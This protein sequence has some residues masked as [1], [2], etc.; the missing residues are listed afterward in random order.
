MTE[1]APATAWDHETDLLVVGSGGGA[2]AAA[3]RGHDLGLRT[4][5]IEKSEHWG[6][7]TAISGGGLWIVG[8]PDA[9]AAGDSTEKGYAYL[10]SVVGDRVPDVRLRAYLETAPRMLDWLHGATRA[11]Y[12]ANPSFPDYYP[13]APGAMRIRTL[14]PDPIDARTL[15]AEYFRMRPG[16]RSL[17]LFGMTVG[18]AEARL[19]M[20]RLP[21][22]RWL[23]ARNVL[24]FWLDFPWRFRSRRDRILQSGAALSASLRRSMMDRNLVLWLETPMRRLFVEGGRVTGVEAEQKGRKIRIRVHRAVILG[25][26]GYEKSAEMRARHLPQPSHIDWTATTAP[27]TG[28]AQRA[29]EA[30]GAALD[31]MDCA[32]WSPTVR[33]PG[34]PQPP[35]FVERAQPGLIAVNRQGRRFVNE[36]YSYFR[37]GRALYA[38]EGANLPAWFIFD[39]AFR[40]KYRIGPLWP[41]VALPDWLLPRRW[42]GTCYF[43]AS[44]LNELAC[45]IGVDPAGLAETV[46]RINR[47]AETGIDEDFAKG[48]NSFDLAFGDPAHTPN[49]CLGPVR[50]PP[51]YAM[52][53]FPGDIGTKG[54]LVCDEHARVLRPDGSVIE[55][56]Y[57]I[58]NSSAAVTGNSY[59]GAGSPITSAMTFG[60]IAA[61]HVAA[62]LAAE[63]AGADMKRAAPER[64]ARPVAGA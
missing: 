25:A 6:G 41:S 14:Q 62:A 34:H 15:G 59:P 11:R 5:M 40:A 32:W 45:Q 2:M 57:A 29:G 60:F 51:F 26:G 1:P 19:M 20:Q 33:M 9:L 37:F 52:Q 61:N 4:L 23:L 43:R 7:T 22:W 16:L 8:T 42:R 35:L 49:P 44:S 50:R 10:K 27:N 31:L 64:A 48:G 47:F 12:R 30:I 13:D 56:L 18:L 55:G 46:A 24:R 17:T 36:A 38:D 39:A 3:I 28:D 58:G 63:T 53:A 21:G 54:G